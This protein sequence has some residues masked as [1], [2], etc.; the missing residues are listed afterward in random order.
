MNRGLWMPC[1]LSL[2]TGL[3]KTEAL[4]LLVFFLLSGSLRAADALR[5]YYEKDTD[6]TLLLQIHP[7]SVPESTIRNSIEE[8]HRSELFFKL[9]IQVSSGSFFSLRGEHR[10]IQIR[11]TGFRDLITGDYVLL[12]NDREIAVFRDWSSFY[13][14]FAAPFPYR[15]NI[16][17]NDNTRVRIRETLIYKKLVPPFNIL[18][19]LP[20]KFIRHESWVEIPRRNKQ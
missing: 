6:G 19:L 5:S 13:R 12:Q 20:E 14:L 11:K 8:G 10:E 9:R 7:S 2:K 18:Y 15:T 3:R 1:S 4:F 17:W 16:L